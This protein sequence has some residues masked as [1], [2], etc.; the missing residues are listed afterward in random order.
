[1]KYFLS[2]ILT[3]VP[4]LGL[5]ILPS[6]AGATSS[7]SGEYSIKSSVKGK[8]TPKVTVRDKLLEQKSKLLAEIKAL[9]ETIEKYDA[10]IHDIKKKVEARKKAGIKENG[11]L[12]KKMNAIIKARSLLKKE[13]TLL[14]SKLAYV[15]AK[16]K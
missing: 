7:V 15:E 13:L 12:I 14:L 3:L 6:S 10:A 8:I 9:K 2:L 1:M 4:L 5:V 11:D 16:L